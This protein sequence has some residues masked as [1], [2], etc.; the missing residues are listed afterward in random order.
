VV[1]ILITTK[2]KFKITR[3]TNPL[4][5]NSI[6]LFQEGGPGKEMFSS[7]GRGEHPMD[8]TFLY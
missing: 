2:L 1:I 6:L 3:K 4:I 8:L 5:S 7:I